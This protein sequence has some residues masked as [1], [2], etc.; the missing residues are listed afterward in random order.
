MGISGVY[1][2]L[3]PG[4]AGRDVMLRLDHAAIFVLIAGTFT[5]V[6]SILFHGRW[7]WEPLILF[8]TVTAA[9]VALKLA[10]FNEVP[11]WVGLLLYL[12]LGWV[13]VVTGGIL[14]ARYG[15]GFMGSLAW[16]GLAYTFGAVLDYL[17]LMVGLPGVVGPHALFP[18]AVLAGAGLPCRCASSLSCRAPP[19]IERRAL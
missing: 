2:L 12:S 5:P 18:L 3:S 9:A 10:F 6:H 13:G 19:G 16:G 17:G 14:W 8:W 4:G 15:W 1:H 11:E 7:R